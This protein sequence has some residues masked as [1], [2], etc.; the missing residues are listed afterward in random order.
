MRSRLLIP[1]AVG[2]AVVLGGWLLG[3]GRSAPNVFGGRKD[4]HQ[5][6]GNPVSLRGGDP[7]SEPPFE[8]VRSDALMWVGHSTLT[9]ERLRMLSEMD[10]IR[11]GGPASESGLLLSFLERS[12][13]RE[14]AKQVYGIDPS[15]EE[16]EKKLEERE[17]D[18]ESADIVGKLLALLQGDRRL[19]GE[20]LIRP[21]L[22]EA[23]LWQRFS[24]DRTIHARPYAESEGLRSAA[25]ANP[26]RFSVLARSVIDGSASPKPPPGLDAGSFPQGNPGTPGGEEA[27]FSRNSVVLGEGALGP[28]TSRPILPPLQGVLIDP[29]ILASLQPGQIYPQVL[30]TPDSLRV[31]RLTHLDGNTALIESWSW[32]KRNYEEWLAEQ[33]RSIPKGIADESMEQAL[34]SLPVRHWLRAGSR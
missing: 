1:A 32:S 13:K 25:L 19:L 28:G 21:M 8:G 6:A 33:S 24:Y 9:R 11:S 30:D 22:V 29:Q 27:R 26:D 23:Q 3:S 5:A 18:L 20:E 12:L 34:Q 17:G 4:P 10:R 2:V 15:P 14:I 7:A 16:L 31:V